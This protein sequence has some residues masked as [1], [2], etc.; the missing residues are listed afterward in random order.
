MGLI[1]VD[2]SVW[3]DH[4]KHPI[5]ELS[6]M[7]DAGSSVLHPFV[8]AEIALGNLADWQRRVDGLR[9]LPAAEP[10]SG[11]ILLAAI[12]DLGLQG[13]GLGFVDA[14][15]LAWAVAAPDRRLWSRDRR[16]REQAEAAG[17]AW[18]PD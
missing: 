5:A 4:I 14:H 7:L 2:T 18:R 10:V 6:R 16:L 1:L 11:E 17:I 12:S 15:L 9:R 13:S 3:I 8:L